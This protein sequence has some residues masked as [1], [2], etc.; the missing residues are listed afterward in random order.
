M[1]LTNDDLAALVTEFCGVVDKI[2]AKP[3]RDV[4]ANLIV[5]GEDGK[6]MQIALLTDDLNDHRRKPD[7]MHA[8]AK[9]VVSQRIVPAA[10][11]MASEVWIAPKGW[12]GRASDCPARQEGIMVAVVAADFRTMMACRSVA[13]DSQDNIVAEDWMPTDS[14]TNRLLEEFYFGYD[15][16]VIARGFT[17][18]HCPSTGTPSRN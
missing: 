14:G 1:Q 8:A 5:V 17:T 11:V 6:R 13:R 15:A 10:V 18:S 9:A 3:T 4:P 12:S 2:L 16:A 7:L